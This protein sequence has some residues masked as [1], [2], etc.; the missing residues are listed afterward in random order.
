MTR[1][2]RSRLSNVTEEAGSQSAAVGLP[3]PSTQKPPERP[4]GK[5]L[6][7]VVS[8]PQPAALRQLM[9]SMETPVGVYNIPA[10]GAGSTRNAKDELRDGLAA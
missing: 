8:E 6:I 9:K 4:R 5:E 2:D 3:P 7:V 10:A 1:K